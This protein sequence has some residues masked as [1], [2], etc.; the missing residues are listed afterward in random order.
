LEFLSALKDK[1]V[2]NID[3]SIITQTDYRKY[4]WMLPKTNTLQ[5]KSDRMG[6]VSL[7]MGVASDGRLFFTANRGSNNGST[8]FLF[9][10]KLAAQLD[11]ENPEWRD[12]TIL[13]LDNAP[14]HR[15][16]KL[17][18]KLKEVN[19]PL[20]YLGPYQFKMAPIEICFGFIKKF[21]VN[22]RSLKVT[23]L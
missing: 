22:E 19:I 15:G 13:L 3:E 1:V 10:K 9:L 18:D 16:N 8:V 4:S 23:T 21:D 12:T 14:Y 20:A 6:Q 17:K 7:I 5:L 2:I 11:L